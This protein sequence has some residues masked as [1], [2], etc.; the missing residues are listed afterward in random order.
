MYILWR[1][2]DDD[3]RYKIG[4]DDMMAIDFSYY[5]T[6]MSL[7]YHHVIMVNV[8]AP[9]SEIKLEIQRVMLV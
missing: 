8:A 2:D 9:F 5:I 3:A 6:A 7:S 1:W 4:D